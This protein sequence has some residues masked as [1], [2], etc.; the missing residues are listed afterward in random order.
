M[1]LDEKFQLAVEF[2]LDIIGN[3]HAISRAFL[4][5]INLRCGQGGH[6]LD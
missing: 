5:K 1:L 4:W 2:F 6:V 3:L